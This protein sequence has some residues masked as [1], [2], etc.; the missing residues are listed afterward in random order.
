MRR[1]KK[2]TSPPA[3]VRGSGKGKGEHT[4]RNTDRQGRKKIVIPLIHCFKE[5]NLIKIVVMKMLRA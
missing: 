3:R 4:D 1:K 5:V 2:K